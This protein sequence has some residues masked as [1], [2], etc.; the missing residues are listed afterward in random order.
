MGTTRSKNLIGYDIKTTIHASTLRCTYIVQIVFYY[1]S[2][3][4]DHHEDRKK[5]Q[6][7]REKV[8]KP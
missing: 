8:T 3:V 4:N 6:E 5:K 7:M 2:C 1:D